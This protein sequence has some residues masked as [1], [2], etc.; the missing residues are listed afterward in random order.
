MPDEQKQAESTPHDQ[1]E[2]TSTPLAG[3]RAPS[4]RGILWKLYILG[5]VGGIIAGYAT[6]RGT[7]P[8]FTEDAVLLD[9]VRSSAIEEGNYQL[10]YDAYGRPV[11][12]Q[13][14]PESIK[15]TCGLT[16][17]GWDSH[18][19]P[20]EPVGIDPAKEDKEF[21]KKHTGLTMDEVLALLYGE[22]GFG[23]IPQG[24]EFAKYVKTLPVAERIKPIATASIFVLSGFALGYG[25]G[26]EPAPHCEEKQIKDTL[27]SAP[28]AQ[29]LGKDEMS[30]WTTVE[31]SD[32]GIPKL[33]TN[34]DVVT[35]GTFGSHIID[36]SER[37]AFWWVLEYGSPCPALIVRTDQLMLDKNG[38]EN[39]LTY[40]KEIADWSWK[41][42]K[43][44]DVWILKNAR[45]R[46]DV[47]VKAVVVEATTANCKVRPTAPSP[48]FVSSK[49]SRN[50]RAV[51]A[52][53]SKTFGAPVKSAPVESLHDLE[54]QSRHLLD[55]P[56]AEK[57]KK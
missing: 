49:S 38:V 33:V 44:T 30:D 52:E 1:T 15:F 24:Y 28:F 34:P 11:K 53:L 36:Y 7:S 50:A 41:T 21:R 47:E 22:A 55:P 3:Q 31:Y 43:F 10:A 5:F 51:V 25:W 42:Q 56:S 26:Y 23:L 17:Y 37:P 4:R 40:E 9:Y 6:G 48:P 35:I 39:G 45:F 18:L 57:T 54:W 13:R 27:R 14:I 32:N 19:K 20:L 2:Q 8:A 12:A 16:E 46:G 29:S